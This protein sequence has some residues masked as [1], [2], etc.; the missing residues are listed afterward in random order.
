MTDKAN[1][2]IGQPLFSKK[3]RVVEC[4]GRFEIQL[5]IEYTTCISSGPSGKWDTLKTTNTIPDAAQWCEDYIK[6]VNKT[7]ELNIVKEYTF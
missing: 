1:L 5:W 6:T 3:L 2:L 7:E 4:Q